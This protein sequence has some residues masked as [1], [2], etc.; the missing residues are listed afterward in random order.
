MTQLRI[1][2]KFK[3]LLTIA[4]ILV[5]SIL[6][7]GGVSAYKSYQ[8]LNKSTEQNLLEV[9]EI[10]ASKI[11]A[12][13]QEELTLLHSLA[14][15]PVIKDPSIGVYEKCF[16]ISAIS[17]ANR[18]KYENV[19]MYDLE[20]NTFKSDGAPINL[21]DRIYFKVPRE[22]GIDYIGDPTLSPV[23]NEVY[24]YYAIPV[25]GDSGNIVG[26][27]S[28][29]IRGN[30]L[31]AVAKQIDVGAGYH[32]DIINIKT[33]VII[34]SGAEDTEEAATINDVDPNSEYGKVLEKVKAG[35]SSV[36]IYT[37]SITGEKF[38]A[39]FKPVGGISDWAV[40]CKAPYDFYYG[41]V[42]K[43][44][45]LMV[46]IMAIAILIAIVVSGIIISILL[47]PLDVLKKSM[48]E[49]SSGNA[50]L[51]KRIDQ[52]TND[53]IGDVVA[54]FNKFTDMLQSIMIQLNKS[55]ESLMAV[56]EKLG[57]CTNE[58]SASITQIIVNIDSVHN[59][60]S[61]Q[62]DSVNQTAGA[63]SQISSNIES[64]EHM[65]E[66]Q[67]AGVAQASAAVEEMVESIKSVTGSIDKMASSFDEL[68]ESAK[69]GLQIQYDVNEKIETIRSQS[70]TL[71]EANLAISSIAEQ[72][73]LLAMN[74][75]IEAAHAG[76]AG[77]GFS[78]VADEIRKLSETSGSQS[79]TIGEQLDHIINSISVVVNSSK[80][81][82]K[83]FNEVTERIEETDS[84]VQQIKSAMEEQNVGSKQ[85]S[86]A[87]QN[88]NDNT[89]EVSNASK[90]MAQGNK[91]ILE[92][93]QNLQV[94]TNEISSSMDEMAVGADH[95]NGTGAEL[96][97]I[98]KQMSE[99]ILEIENNVDQFRI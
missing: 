91:L 92:K 44:I 2:M 43:L 52:N 97:G 71:K 88:M 7:V 81:L 61:N 67:T 24:M 87:L 94:V 65:I 33:G 54:G 37:D 28:A 58:T 75:A 39:S 36:E 96:T 16:Q 57:N 86:E 38:V 11:N 9:S 72:T 32:P 80:K 48:H 59:Q 77:K 20:G 18:E 78:V 56:G 41:S 23:T 51:T 14:L 76:E 69:S 6:I 26:V 1:T 53:E 62:N 42:S 79:R 30:R 3:L 12:I 5:L 68:I 35:E 84:V 64:L 70:E 50:D 82:N 21:G 83:A 46:I 27:M 73:N 90:E 34:G 98:S 19:T 25:K 49:I 45:R 60:V 8:A 15:L 40:L 66:N 55:K 17:S 74:A 10:A 93:I 89:I 85:I 47:K 31:S 22:S 99:S 4:L 29:M 63:V 95:I 13:N